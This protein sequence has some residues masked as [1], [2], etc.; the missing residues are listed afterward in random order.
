[1]PTE[2]TAG[3]ELGRI[4]RTVSAN[5]IRRKLNSAAD[6]IQPHPVQ[7]TRLIMERESVSNDRIRSGVPDR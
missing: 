4:A 7:A 5:T 6:A 2:V 1:M 3:S